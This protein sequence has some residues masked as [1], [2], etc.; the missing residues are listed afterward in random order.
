MRLSLALC[1]VLFLLCSLNVGC[2]S[3]TQITTQ[4]PGAQVTVDGMRLGKSPTVY[5]NSQVWLWTKHSVS[6]KKKGYQPLAG[7]LDAQIRPVNLICGILLCYTGIGLVVA[8]AGEL[9][10][11]KNFSLVRVGVDG[12]PVEEMSYEGGQARIDFA[13]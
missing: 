3:S 6:V 2:A 11:Q 7:S 8:A 9:P 10:P 4:P 13:P 1:S 5:T 12:V